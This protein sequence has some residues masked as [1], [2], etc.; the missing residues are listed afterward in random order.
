MDEIGFPYVLLM[1][2]RPYSLLAN[3]VICY[4]RH[5]LHTCVLQ[6]LGLKSYPIDIQLS[7]I[8]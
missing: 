5:A 2:F 7:I 4:T 6:P 1:F 3:Q 8:Y